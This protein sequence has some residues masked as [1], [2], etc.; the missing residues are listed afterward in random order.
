MDEDLD[1]VLGNFYSEPGALRVRSYAAGAK[2]AGSVNQHT[3][4]IATQVEERAQAMEGDRLGPRGGSL[5]RMLQ[6]K[7][8]RDR[9]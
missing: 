8:R 3:H 5:A 6:L 7:K 1:A 2:Q 9:L 4:I